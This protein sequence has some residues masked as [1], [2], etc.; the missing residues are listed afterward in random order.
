VI[1][2]I[3]FEILLAVL[4]LFAGRS[5]WQLIKRGRFLK[6]VIKSKACLQKLISLDRLQSQVSTNSPYLQKNELG[7]DINIASLLSSDRTTQRLVKLAFGSIV[8]ILLI[9]S[10]YLGG[11]FFLINLMIF[12]SLNLRPLSIS[13]QRNT[14]DHVLTLAA[15][16]YKW[17]KEDA[18]KCDEWVAMAWSLKDIYAAVQNAR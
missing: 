13:A 14:Y 6:T 7:Y 11:I 17:R 12:I 9:A 10:Y 18:K 4:M 5:F 3:I 16:L 2:A 1:A 8:A 15:I